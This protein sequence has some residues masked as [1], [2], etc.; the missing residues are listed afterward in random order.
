M[1]TII[2]ELIYTKSVQH[3]VELALTQPRELNTVLA[4]YISIQNVNTY[5]R[6]LSFICVNRHIPSTERPV[7]L[8]ASTLVEQDSLNPPQT[9]PW[10]SSCA[11]CFTRHA[12]IH[13]FP[14]PSESRGRTVG[15]GGQE[16][17]HRTKQDRRLRPCLHLR[18]KD[19]SQAADS[20]MGM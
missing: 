19:V 5:L 20:R 11:R 13:L 3:L 16:T 7:T 4:L 14:L 12:P 6:T 15:S 18:V 2:S 17:R 10:P 9:S 1:F 8:D